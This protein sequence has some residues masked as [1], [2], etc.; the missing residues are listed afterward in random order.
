MVWDDVLCR[1]M[2]DAK[3]KALEKEARLQK[4]CHDRDAV[5]V[6]P[7]KER[8]PLSDRIA[9]RKRRAALSEIF[10][11]LLY[12][13]DMA[14]EQEAQMR[15]RDEQ[16]DQPSPPAV[17]RGQEYDMGWRTARENGEAAY[18]M[19][20]RDSVDGGGYDAEISRTVDR[21]LLE[22]GDSVEDCN[23][24]RN[25]MRRF[26]S[27]RCSPPPA[28][29]PPPRQ[30]ALS[31]NKYYFR[32][33]SIANKKKQRQEA[34]RTIDDNDSPPPPPVHVPSE[35][36]DFDEARDA[37]SEV[38]AKAMISKEH[39][40]NPLST[41]ST[42]H[43]WRRSP[44]K[45]KPLL[46]TVR[47]DASLLRPRV[48]GGVVSMVLESCRPSF[49]SRE[50]FIECFEVLIEAG[51][52]PPLNVI[53]SRPN[54]AR[55]DR[56][57]AKTRLTSEE[58]EFVDECRAAPLLHQGK[59]AVKLRNKAAPASTKEHVEHLLECMKHSCV[60]CIVFVVMV[61]IVYRQ[62]CCADEEGAETEGARGGEG[63]GPHL[64]TC[65]FFQSNH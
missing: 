42:L 26:N 23:V 65:A 58:R 32:A 7:L 15:P 43:L 17:V 45:D 51:L 20:P 56:T 3:A 54:D 59:R 4:E 47:A 25:L 24:T 2:D 55:K 21:A 44:K 33:E 34:R 29:P 11:V 12:A 39:L 50:E 53:F 60:V 48:L 27:A 31:G 9:A 10:T 30:S 63:K 6:S 14:R 62:E 52:A 1:R 64:P 57:I 46:D 16:H 36:F 40:S 41:D 22:G 5:Q 37:P 61:N 49:I 19:C 18:E 38:P 28:P 13:V 35:I 8:N